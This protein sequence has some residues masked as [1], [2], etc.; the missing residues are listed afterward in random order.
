MD[1]QTRFSEDWRSRIQVLEQLLVSQPEYAWLWEIRLK[2]MRFLIARYGTRQ[3]ASGVFAD[4]EPESLVPLR[5]AV[6]ARPIL[7]PNPPQAPRKPEH[8][9]ELLEDIHEA[10]SSPAHSA[11]R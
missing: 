5:F 11:N 2:I 4:A 8:L 3:F 1:D 10:V 9:R 7:P 6:D